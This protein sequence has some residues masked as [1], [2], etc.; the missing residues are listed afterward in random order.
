[1]GWQCYHMRLNWVSKS[2]NKVY[3]LNIHWA[4]VSA[5]NK[6]T[7]AT[8]ILEFVTEENI[9]I[10]HIAWRDRVCHLL[11][12]CAYSYKNLRVRGWEKNR[13]SLGSV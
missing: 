4:I 6:S 13:S 7:K 8:A 11:T 5:I 1:M 10:T 9:A 2:L 12:V 3:S